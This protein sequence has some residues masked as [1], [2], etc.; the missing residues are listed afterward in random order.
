MSKKEYR[1]ECLVPPA[2]ER[3]DASHVFD[4]I[5]L[6]EHGSRMLGAARSIEKVAQALQASGRYPLVT[7]CNLAMTRQH[8]EETIQRLGRQDATL[9]VLP[10]FLDDGVHSRG[11]IP[12]IVRDIGKAYPSLKL[13][14]GMPLGFDPL[15]VEL[16]GKRISECTK[17]I[18]G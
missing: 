14:M 12:N 18:E 16:V 15:L 13:V 9:L 17:R 3:C 6:V 10:Y 2:S 4:A 8:V 1:D 7:T 11:D 5:I